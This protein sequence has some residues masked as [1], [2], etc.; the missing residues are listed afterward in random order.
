MFCCV[1][2]FL[3]INQFY[4]YLETAYIEER[5]N[6]AASLQPSIDL[7]TSC[8]LLNGSNNSSLDSVSD[9]TVSSNREVDSDS[10]GDTD[11]EL[12]TEVAELPSGT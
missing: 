9:C 3:L 10:I 4:Y 8:D 1:Y 7:P 12:P 6:A 2:N 11:N 5:D